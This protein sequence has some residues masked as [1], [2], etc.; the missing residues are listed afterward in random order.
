MVQKRYDTERLT[1]IISKPSMAAKTTRY[2]RKN[3]QFLHEF[4]PQY[5]EL[6]YEERGQKRLLA[7]DV[8]DAA[9]GS[10]YKYWLFKNENLEEVIGMVA[11]IHVIRGSF[12]SCFVGY[13]LDQDMQSNGYMTEAVK[14]MT[15][16]AFLDLGLH[17]IEANIMPRNRASLRVA[18]K[19]GY[20]C[21]G[22]ARRYMN[23]N[24][25]WED[26]IHMVRLSDEPFYSLLEKYTQEHVD[27]ANQ[28]D[29]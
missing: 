3:R 26:H 2:Y 21:E 13:N 20:Q 29:P 27:A 1:L 28:V 6:F 22:I 5:H 19:A 7:A 4:L 8:R 9:D 16:V 15:E 10:G 18:E 25:V 14:K 23:I 12:M 24:G 11:L 17:R